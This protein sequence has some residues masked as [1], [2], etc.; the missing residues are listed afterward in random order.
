MVQH[1]VCTV[2]LL[3][4]TVE[5]TIVTTFPSHLCNEEEMIWLSPHQWGFERKGLVPTCPSQ[6]K[7][8]CELSTLLSAIQVARSKA[9][10]NDSFKVK[11]TQI[12]ESLLE[13]RF[14]TDLFDLSLSVPKAGQSWVAM[15]F[16]LIW[17]CSH[18]S[19]HLE[20]WMVTLVKMEIFSFL[21]SF[22]F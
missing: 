4:F 12:P 1:Q 18:I 10:Q 6:L 14:W 15:R 11:A 17:V 2:E 3:I 13:Q 7:C 16:E 21:F 5:E 19:L 9:L 20:E 8:F 22:L